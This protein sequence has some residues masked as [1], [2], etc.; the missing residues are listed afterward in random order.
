VEASQPV[1]VPD[2]AKPM[3]AT[4]PV[5]IPNSAKPKKKK[6]RSRATDSFTG[7]FNGNHFAHKSDKPVKYPI[8]HVIQNLE[9]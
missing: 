1:S 9:F 6:R 3:E 2:S 8:T 5:S 7:N 4:Q